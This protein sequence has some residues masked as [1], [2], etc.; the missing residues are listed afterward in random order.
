MEIFYVLPD[1]YEARPKPCMNGWGNRFITVNPAGEVLPCPTA[2]GI[3]GM[4]FENVLEHPLAWIWNESE[5]FNRFR[6]TAWMP[7]PCQSCPQRE[8]DFGGCRCQAALLTGDAAKTDPVCTLRR[9]A[10]SWT[11]FSRGFPTPVRRR[12]GCRGKTLRPRPKSPARKPCLIP[13]SSTYHYAP[14]NPILI[15]HRK[16]RTLEARNCFIFDYFFSPQVCWRR[17]GAK[18][19]RASRS[20][21]GRL[22]PGLES[23]GRGEQDGSPSTS[24]RKSPPSTG[25]QSRRR[26]RLSASDRASHGGAVCACAATRME[27]L[28]RLLVRTAETSTASEDDTARIWDARTGLQLGPALQHG[29]EV[30]MAEFSPDGTRVVTASEDKT[31]RVWEVR[32]GKPSVRPCTKRTR[33]CLPGSARTENLWPLGRKKG[34]VVFGMPKL[35]NRSR[36]RSGIMEISFPLISA[37]TGPG[38]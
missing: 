4:H 18:R 7:E 37:R 5:S 29:G 1:Y 33:C 38:L 32:S 36:R 12:S 19:S 10:K 3:S 27:L 22:S 20:A 35:A 11:T 15:R 14:L 30:A 28:M 31:A 16:P 9:I 23:G 8:I 21:P 34:R 6:G 2:S 25:E 13:V 26:S 17:R 24:C